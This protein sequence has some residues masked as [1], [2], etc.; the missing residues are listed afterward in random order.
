MRA[1]PCCQ[2]GRCRPKV[3]CSRCAGVQRELCGRAP[4]VGKALVGTGV[5]LACTFQR[6]QLGGLSRRAVSMTKLA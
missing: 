2:G 1:T 6:L 4:G 5:D 3:C